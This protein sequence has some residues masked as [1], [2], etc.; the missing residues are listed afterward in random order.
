MV[1]EDDGLI[2]R[3]IVSWSVKDAAIDIGGLFGDADERYGDDNAAVPV[4]QCVLQGKTHRREGLATT[5]RDGET[6]EAGRQLGGGEA[7]LKDLVAR[8]ADY[9]AALA[10]ELPLVALEAFPK[11]SQR[12]FGATLRGCFFS[13]VPLG[14]QEVGVYEGG[15]EQAHEQLGG[16]AFTPH[17][18]R[19]WELL[20]RFQVRQRLASQIERFPDGGSARRV[21]EP[22]LEVGGRL[23]AAVVTVDEQSEC[24]KMLER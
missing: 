17:R 20:P 4:T 3:A 2:V 14:V 7:V 11:H 5:G 18:G 23:E 21:G 6:E 22:R 1:L 19:K 13:K 8:S 24:A 15:E 9:P 12:H 10:R 16:Q